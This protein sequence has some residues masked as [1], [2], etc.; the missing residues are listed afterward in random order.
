MCRGDKKNASNSTDVAAGSRP[1]AWE[2]QCGMCTLINRPSHSMCEMCGLP[3]GTKRDGEAS[4]GARSSGEAFEP[5]VPKGNRWSTSPSAGW[6]PNGRNSPSSS[7]GDASPQSPGQQIL[8]SLKP[9]ANGRFL[10]TPEKTL[11]PAHVHASPPAGKDAGNEILA[12]LRCGN[13]HVATNGSRRVLDPAHELLAA[14]KSGGAAEKAVVPDDVSQQLLAVLKNGGE[15]PSP[16]ESSS[17]RPQWK[18]A[19][20]GRRGAYG[21]GDWPVYSQAA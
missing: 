14:L 12:A 3:R 11:H 5:A 16:S 13:S 15:V 18:A 10:L 20:K 6:S 21:V 9:K 8:A 17:G 2:W 19:R 4:R 1:N 7:A